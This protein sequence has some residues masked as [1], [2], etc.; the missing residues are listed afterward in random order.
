M[1]LIARQ[2]EREERIEIERHGDRYAVRVGE[3]LYE[4]DA[5]SASETGRSYL[6]DGAQFEV[7]VKSLGNGRYQVS[8]ARDLSQVEV[9]DPLTHLAE[10]SRAGRGGATLAVSAYMPGRVV[11]ILVAEGDEVEAGQGI[12]VLEAMKMEN[13]IQSE[14]AGTVSK[15]LVEPGQPVEKNDPLFEVT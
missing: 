13:E 11:E 9:C 15:I 12:L 1:E 6:I 8:S 5:V 7:G 3:T 2:D 10:E 4:V 14:R